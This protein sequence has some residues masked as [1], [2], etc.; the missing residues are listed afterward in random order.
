MIVGIKQITKQTPARIELAKGYYPRAAT[1]GCDRKFTK[2]SWYKHSNNRDRDINR[3]KVVT[4][5]VD[6]YYL[7]SAE[8]S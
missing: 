7:L 3:E 2:K 4:S 1:S 5:E 8:G 6:C